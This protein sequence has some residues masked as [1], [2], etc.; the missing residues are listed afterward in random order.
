MNK[1]EL[2]ELYLKEPFKKGDYFYVKDK[3]KTTIIDDI[4]DNKIIYKNSYGNIE[5]IDVCEAE[6]SI[7]NVGYD[8][9][10]KIPWD[11]GIRMIQFSIESILRICGWNRNLEKINDDI[12]IPNMCWTPI[13]VDSNG[14]DISYQRDF[15]WSLED[16]QLLLES[17]YNNIDCGKIIVR[18]RSWEWIE[19]RIQN[20][21]IEN[22]TFYDIVDGKQRLKAIYDF[23]SNIYPDKNG[24]FYDDLSNRSQIKFMSSL[25]FSY[26]E[27]G[28]NTSDKEVK[29]VFLNI[30]FTGKQMSKEHIEYVEKINV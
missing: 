22:T 4:I 2:I 29:R 10:T 11:S 28:E 9:F 24:Y 19:N 27:L 18:K 3:I 16:K 23:V 26:G 12:S 8:P 30:N 6:K 15:C 14:N 5:S 20:N 25:L 7:I 21:K 1:K 13:M 17:I